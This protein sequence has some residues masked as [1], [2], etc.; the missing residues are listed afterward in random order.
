M[1]NLT[2]QVLRERLPSEAFCNATPVGRDWPVCALPAGHRP[3]HES[4]SFA[5]ADDESFPEI[6]SLEAQREWDQEDHITP[7]ALN[8]EHANIKEAI[9]SVDYRDEARILEIFVIWDKTEIGQIHVP[10][11]TQKELDQV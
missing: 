6:K 8:P 7:P 11:W 4:A 10:I 9:A 3:V 1:P 5:W 2:I